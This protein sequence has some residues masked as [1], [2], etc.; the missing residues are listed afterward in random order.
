M[1]TNY[2]PYSVYVGNGVTTQFTFDFKIKNANQVLIMVFDTT[3]DSL[4]FSERGNLAPSANVTSVTFDALRGGGTVTLPAAPSA[5]RAILVKLAMDTPVQDYKFR[6]QQ[7]FELRQFENS[8]DFLMSHIQRLYEKI[9]RTLRF[10]DKM[11]YKPAAN[12]E[13]A[14]LPIPYGIPIFDDQGE[15]MTI[16]TISDIIA[17]SGS[18]GIGLP[19]GGNLGDTLISDGAGSG[20]WEPMAFT[21]F[22]A[23]FGSFFTSTGL[24]DTLAKILNIS[25]VAPSISL[26]GS[27]S[28]TIREKGA[29]VASVNLT[30]NVTKTSD[31]IQ[32]VEF[33]QGV[34][35]L[36]ADD[37]SANPNGGSTLYTYSTPFSDNISFTA[38]AT[39]DGS[40]GGPTTVTSNT[41]TYNFVYPYYYG[42]GSTGLTGAAIAALTKDIIASTATVNRT[43]AAGAG[44]V[45]YFAYPS[46]YPA[47]TSIL[48][49]NNFETITDWTVRTV[50]ITGLDATSQTYRVY[51]FN[52]PVVAGSYF[53]S[54]RR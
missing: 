26:S 28:G 17:A 18:G 12:T 14:I 16:M 44:Q 46:A 22:S 19:A 53:Y 21:G 7:D 15:Q 11:T 48:D 9:S 5:Q 20:T 1:I 8:L 23:R 37:P 42:A 51:E 52:N 31:P 49:V 3:N 38:Q 40:T 45:F 2:Q 24:Q 35:S 36:F 50:T 33:F 43:I 39:D 30:A 29:T 13:I 4:V 25:Y 34:T 27:G 41:V 32:R 6:E 47:L 10:D 54:F